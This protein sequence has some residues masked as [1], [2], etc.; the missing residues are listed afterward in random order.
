MPPALRDA[1]C[2]AI[3]AADFRD[4]GDMICA[5][6]IIHWYGQLLIFRAISISDD[7]FELL[8]SRAIDDTWCQMPWCRYYFRALRRA[9]DFLDAV[10]SLCLRHFRLRAAFRVS[11]FYTLCYATFAAAEC[12]PF[13]SSDEYALAFFF[14]RCHLPYAS[15]AA[16]ITLLI[17]AAFR[18]II[19]LNTPTFRHCRLRR[20]FATGHFSLMSL[21]LIF[22]Y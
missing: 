2:F 21:P 17:Y 7:Y 16:A 13:V 22:S 5:F 8:L 9:Y 19:T 12:L 3:S 1:I 6:I 14:F 10:I 20:H 11:S 4:A 15:H 18:Y